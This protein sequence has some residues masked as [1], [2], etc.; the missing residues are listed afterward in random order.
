MVSRPATK[1]NAD[2]SPVKAPEYQIEIL[3]DMSDLTIEIDDTNFLYGAKVGIYSL[4][5]S[6]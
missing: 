5:A 2:Q 3:N 6:L 1:K 4:D